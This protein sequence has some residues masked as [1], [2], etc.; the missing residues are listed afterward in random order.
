M[1]SKIGEHNPNCE[2]LDDR[3]IETH[4]MDHEQGYSVKNIVKITNVN[5]SPIDRII[6]CYDIFC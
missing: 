3:I 5:K 1:F 4:K 2:I 6:Y